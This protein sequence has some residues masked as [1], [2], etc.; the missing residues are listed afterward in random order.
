MGENGR[1]DAE[2]MVDQKLS[3]DG[4]AN[5]RGAVG[6]SWEMWPSFDPAKK[7]VRIDIPVRVHVPA[8]SDYDARITYYVYLFIDGAYRLR[9]FTN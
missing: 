7:F 6:F 1:A 5:R 8:W 9:G 2:A 4:R 3:N